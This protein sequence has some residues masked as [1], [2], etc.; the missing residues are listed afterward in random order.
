[1]TP[2]SIVLS[3]DAELAWGFHDLPELPTAR[4]TEA[5]ESW[6]TLVELF[7]QYDVPATWTVVGSLFL[8]ELDGE[9]GTH[10]AGEAWFE[11]VPDG[12][13]GPESVWFSQELIEAVI[14]SPVDHEIGSHS[15]S[16]IEFGETTAEIAQ[17]EL[18]FSHDAASTHGIDLE[19]FVF[20]RNNVGHRRVLAENGFTCYRGT[21]PERWYEGTRY[22]PAGKA[23]TFLLGLSPPPIVTPQQDEFGLVNIP[24]SLFLFEFGR[25]PPPLSTDPVVRQVARGLEALRAEPDGVLH[26]WLHPNNL[27]TAGDRSRL[28]EIL[29]LVAEYRDTHGVPVETMGQVATRVSGRG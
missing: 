2:G 5:R 14:E 23:A 7:E 17:A 29:S 10:P 22:E 12:E 6:Q 4:V 1:M 13:P 27:T 21:A 19:S 16:H 18:E 3:L 15:F 20:P 26:L 9:E 28:E 25:A 11:R 8:D 24:A